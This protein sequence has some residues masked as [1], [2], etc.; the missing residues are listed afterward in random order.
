MVDNRAE[1]RDFLRSRRARISPDAVGLPA[2]G[3][4]RRVQGLRREEVAT[5][6]GVSVDYYNRMERG[7]LS[8]VSEQVL[9][10]VAAALQLDDAERAHLADL[11]RTAN[12]GQHRRRV[13]PRPRVRP[14]VQRILDGMT[15]TPAYVRNGWYDILAVNA[16]GAAL[17]P[18]LMNSGGPGAANLARY[19]FLDPQAQQFYAEWE[20]VA[21]DSVAALR[22][23]AGREPYNRGLTDLVGEL[24]TRSDAFRTWWATHDVRL[25]NSATKLMRHPVVGDIE[26]T[27]EA[28]TLPADPGLTIIAYTVEPA[29]SS[30]Q[31]LAILESWGTHEQTPVT[32][33]PTG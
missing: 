8:G 1:V 12:A 27:G 15:H 9:E 6:A 13:T 18:D 21:R 29:S 32:N 25:H 5:L 24:S 16:L 7:S 11:A 30:A 26:V 10:A 2:F 33:N 22:I 14:V 3:G 28:L 19:L 20:S 23:E 31:A 4:S 17:L